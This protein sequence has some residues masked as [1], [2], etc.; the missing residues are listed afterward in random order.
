MLGAG[1]SS[2]QRLIS[3]TR[4]AEGIVCLNVDGSMLGSGQAA[5]FGGLIRNS[6]G[7]F[8]KGFYGKASL[9]R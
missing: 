9:L 2:E 3:W 4:P 1:R 7:A 5:G 8:L 6:S